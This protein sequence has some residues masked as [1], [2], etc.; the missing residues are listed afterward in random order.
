VP[1]LYR[2]IVGDETMLKERVEAL[3]NK[4]S[5]CGGERE[6][7]V[8]RQANSFRDDEFSTHVMKCVK[9]N[10]VPNNSEHWKNKPIIKNKLRNPN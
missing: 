3:M 8:V 9:P 4:P 5:A 10:F 6:G 1:V 7:V 2:G